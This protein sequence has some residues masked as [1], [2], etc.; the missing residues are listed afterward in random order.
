MSDGSIPAR[1]RLRVKQR[2]WEQSHATANRRATSLSK[3]R[4][5]AYP[6]AVPQKRA[7]CR[8]TQTPPCS[9]PVARNRAW[10]SVKPKS[11]MARTRSSKFIAM[12]HPNA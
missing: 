5:T 6:Y 10:R 1:Y 9:I 4:L 7:Y 2:L 11:E 3:K 12:T 8:G